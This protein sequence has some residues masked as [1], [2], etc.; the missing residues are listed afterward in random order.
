VTT[1]RAITR[2]TRFGGQVTIPGDKSISHRALILGALA[3]GRTE[4]EDILNGGDVQS[5]ARCLRAL[6]VEIENRGT[7]TVVHGT[8][9]AQF[10][11]PEQTLDCGNSGTTLRVLMGVLAGTGLSV[12]LTGDSSLVR[13]P[14]KRVAEPLQRMGARFELTGGDRAPVKVL[15]TALKGIEY[16]LK[17]ASAQVKTAIMLAGLNAEGRTKITGEI[18]SRDHTERM[19]RYFGGN[20]EQGPDFVGVEGGQR[21]H[22]AKVRVPGDP[23]TA[24]FWIGTAA[25]IPGARV[26]LLNVCLNPTRIGFI[27]ALQRMGGKLKISYQ[28]QEPE[29]VGSVCAEFAELVGTRIGAA[30]I[31]TLIDELPLLAVL[32]SQ[33]RGTTIVEGAEELR[34]KET[35]RI[36]AVATNLRALGGQIE[37]RPDGFVIEG[38]QRLTGARLQSFDDHRIAMAFSIAGLCADGTT[39]IEGVDCVGISYPAFFT[40]LDELTK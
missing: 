28:S 15:G 35:D 33:A 4:I 27:Q 17:I 9:S 1:L 34:V 6:G 13:R 14:M 39:E 11:P 24:A 7:L 3:E 8:G 16:P 12:T 40:T 30:E 23:S 37:E 36:A 20:V 2:A 25:L 5:T 10:R 38:P 31:P 29:P 26:E 18:Q 32:A 22:A 21:L 19:L